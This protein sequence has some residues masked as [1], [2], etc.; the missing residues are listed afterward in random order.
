M[1]VKAPKPQVT[2]ARGWFKEGLEMVTG[3]RLLEGAGGRRIPG[4]RSR[5]GSFFSLE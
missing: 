3:W 2:T 5:M 1:G 4:Y